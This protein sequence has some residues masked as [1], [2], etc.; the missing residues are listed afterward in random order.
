MNKR[1]RC[2]EPPRLTAELSQTKADAAA[3]TVQASA[4]VAAANAKVAELQREIDGVKAQ[5]TFLSNLLVGGKARKHR[6]SRKSSDS[7]GGGD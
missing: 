2:D 1:C 3:A 5:N 6:K 4:D 7:E